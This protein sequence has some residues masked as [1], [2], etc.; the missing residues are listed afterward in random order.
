MS[1]VNKDDFSTLQLFVNWNDV[2]DRQ[3]FL[4]LNKECKIFIAVDVFDVSV[5]V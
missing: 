4:F 2:A 1:H 5:T 3:R